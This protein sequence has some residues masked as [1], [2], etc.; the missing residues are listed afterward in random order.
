MGYENNWKKRFLLHCVQQG[1]GDYGPK[2]TD[3]R[4][5]LLYDLKSAKKNDYYITNEEYEMIFSVASSSMQTAMILATQ[6][7]F[8]LDEV[9]NIKL[10]D[11]TSEGIHIYRRYCT[12]Y[13]I[14]LWSNEL[15]N[16]VNKCTQGKSTNSD[17][18]IT[19][20]N[21]EK[22]NKFS[23]LLEWKKTL[24]KAQKISGL[25]LDISFHALRIK[26]KIDS[27]GM[28]QNKI[29]QTTHP[30][31]YREITKE[32]Y[33]VIYHEASTQMRTAIELAYRGTLRVK[34]IIELQE[35]HLTDKGFTVPNYNSSY[36]V[37]KLWSIE[38]KNI[39]HDCL[40]ESTVKSNFLI[41]RKCGAQH[42]RSSFY[43]QWN[44]ML[45][46]AR[47]KSGLALDFTFH[48]LRKSGILKLA[49]TTSFS[50]SQFIHNDSSLCKLQRQCHVL[51]MPELPTLGTPIIA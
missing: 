24:K 14:V 44:T 28:L 20:G 34:E 32:E 38:L 31:R 40:S 11:L 8:R 27:Q 4:E 47:M 35:T 36:L 5:T 18:L 23:F 12:F 6:A 33:D 16:A 2:A 21:G 30:I 46:K 37:L 9:I 22:H 50:C 25:K 43:Y 19:K 7:L 41:H 29:Q 13:E 1:L 42:S 49:Q 10:F 3:D 15:R 17:Y 48:D 26:G 51:R 45:R 39:V